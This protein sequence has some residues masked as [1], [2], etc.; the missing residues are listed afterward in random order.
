MRTRAFV[1]V[2]TV[3]L[4]Y[5]SVEAIAEVNQFTNLKQAERAY[6]YSEAKYAFCEVQSFGAMI[7]LR[8]VDLTKSSNAKVRIGYKRCLTDTPIRWNNNETEVTV[9]L[10]QRYPQLDFGVNGY[11][12]TS[13][14]GNGFRR[15]TDYSVIGGNSGGC[16]FLK[17]DGTVGLNFTYNC[18]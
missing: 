8:Q 18:H 1:S 6:S 7:D 14:N 12:K 17:N 10:N 13:A 16:Y 5:F 11:I 4:I 9:T 3:V 15:E 2:F